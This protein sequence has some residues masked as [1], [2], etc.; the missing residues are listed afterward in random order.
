MEISINSLFLDIIKLIKL[1]I[2]ISI[3]SLIKFKSINIPFIFSV[4]LILFSFIILNISIHSFFLTL[5]IFFKICFL[6]SLMFISSL[7][8]N[9]GSFILLKEYLN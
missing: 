8:S 7:L 5:F 3:L 2:L 6:I 9:E 1:F 4:K